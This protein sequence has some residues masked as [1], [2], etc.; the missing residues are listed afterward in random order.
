MKTVHIYP[1]PGHVLDWMG[2]PA[3]EQDVPAA[4]AE[5][6]CATGA[7]T[8]KPPKVEKEPVTPADKEDAK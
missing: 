3:A 6:L 8:T 1:V 2:I 4:D 5:A 7:F